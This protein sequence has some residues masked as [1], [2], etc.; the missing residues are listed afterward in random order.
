MPLYEYECTDHG[1]FETLRPLAEYA[2]PAPCPDCALPAGRVVSVP[3][4]TSVPRSTRVARERNE[5]SCHDPHHV[6]SRADPRHPKGEPRAA[7]AL[8]A[9]TGKRPWVMEHA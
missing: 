3:N 2:A 4:L 1:V 7:P 9:Y 8:R 6:H 5:R